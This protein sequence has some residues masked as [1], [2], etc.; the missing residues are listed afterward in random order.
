MRDLTSA[1]KEI[2]YYCW[3]LTVLNDRCVYPASGKIW[4][5]MTEICEELNSRSE[6]YEYKEFNIANGGCLCGNPN[7][8]YIS[9][10]CSGC[11]G[12]HGHWKRKLYPVHLSRVHE[13]WIDFGIAHSLSLISKSKVKR[14]AKPERAA[15]ATSEG[16]IRNE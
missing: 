2:I 10:Y 16:V 6:Y 14:L 11:L 8:G 4:P 13:S 9:N 1:E 12:R 15:S 5:A 7:F 3:L